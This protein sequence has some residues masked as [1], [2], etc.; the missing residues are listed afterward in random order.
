MLLE[1]TNNVPVICLEDKKEGYV[2]Y[3][4]DCGN[5]DNDRYAIILKEGGIIRFVTSKQIAVVYNSTY[6]IK[7]IKQ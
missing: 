7:P 4:R 6:D 5:F 2:W 3:V 1:F